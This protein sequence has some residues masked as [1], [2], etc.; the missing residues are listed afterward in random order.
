MKKLKKH[1]QENGAM[2]DFCRPRKITAIWRTD[3]MV[4]IGLACRNHKHKLRELEETHAQHE[5]HL[6][7]ADYQTWMRL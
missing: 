1:V 7:E 5:E 2:C 3:G 6:T 4:H